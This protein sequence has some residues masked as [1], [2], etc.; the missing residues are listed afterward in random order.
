MN[1]HLNMPMNDADLMDQIALKSLINQCF[2]CCGLLKCLNNAIHFAVTKRQKHYF[3]WSLWKCCA[4][5]VS[6]L[7]RRLNCENILSGFYVEP[8]LL[9]VIYTHLQGGKFLF[10]IVFPPATHSPKKPIG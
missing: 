8:L 4:A 7:I 6:A 2:A 3:E 9:L 5:V 1:S 10:A